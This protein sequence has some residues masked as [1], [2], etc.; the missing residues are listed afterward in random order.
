MPD[1]DMS[2]MADLPKAYPGVLPRSSA[3]SDAS[4]G[5]SGA[6]DVS[7]AKATRGTGDSSG[8]RDEGFSA[9]HSTSSRQLAED[10]RARE[11]LAYLEKELKIEKES[12][13]AAMLALKKELQVERESSQAALAQVHTPSHYPRRLL[14]DFSVLDTQ[15]CDLKDMNVCT[16]LSPPSH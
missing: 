14:Q 16:R 10:N 11:K 8:M 2:D 9:A 4:G 3:V 6:R 1:N 13:Q 15:M 7:K 5:I 12:S